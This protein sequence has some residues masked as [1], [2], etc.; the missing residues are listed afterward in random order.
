[1]KGL[2]P[3]PIVV[4]TK[5]YYMYI[6]DR[7]RLER[8]GCLARRRTRGGLG[9]G[10]ARAGGMPCETQYLLLYEGRHVEGYLADID[11]ILISKALKAPQKNRALITEYI[12]KGASERFMSLAGIYNLD[13]ESFV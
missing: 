13:L 8:L 12:A 5:I 1:M 6:H 10:R 4:C 9:Q 7:G 11:A 2:I 3:P